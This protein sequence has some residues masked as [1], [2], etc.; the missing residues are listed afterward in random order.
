MVNEKAIFE[1]GNLIHVR[2][3]WKLQKLSA[4]EIIMSYEY[5]MFK[6]DNPELCKLAEQK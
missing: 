3:N 1:I 4:Q 6:K 5:K 2:K